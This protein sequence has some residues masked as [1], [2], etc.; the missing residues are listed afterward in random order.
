MRVYEF[1]AEGD[2]QTIRDLAE[3]LANTIRI[4]T[5]QVPLASLPAGLIV[6]RHLGLVTSPCLDGQVVHR[7]RLPACVLFETRATRTPGGDYVLMFPDG[8][9]YGGKNTKVNTMLAYRSSDQGRTWTGPTVAFDIDYNQHGFIPLIP[10]G[11]KRIYAFG[12]QPLW[13]KFDGHENAAIGYRFSDDDGRT[14]SPV[15]LT[16]PVNDPGY[17]GMSV[18][19]MCETDRGT[20]LLGTH[21]GDWTRKGKA[22]VV[23]RQYVLRSEDQGQTWTLLP[24]KRPGGWYV[25]EF[26]RMDELRPVG[27]GGGRVLALA[28]TCEGHLWELR[29]ED[30]GKIWTAPKPTPLVHPD[31]PPM[32]F[33]LADGK[34]LAA[35]HH[36]V[37]SG[38]H[39]NMRDRSQLWVSLSTDE[40]RTWSEPRFV[41]ANAL[42]RTLASDFQNDQCSYLDMFADGED[43]H[44]FLPHRWQRAL[45]LHLKSADLNRLPTTADLERAMPRPAPGD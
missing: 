43:L 35:F 14:W 13:N 33:P 24:G 15:Q 17:R 20:W 34:T 21:E 6:R 22:P 16:E 32:L 29:S 19:R 18:M 1:S 5:Q 25:P 37:H 39:F 7:A 3:R 2:L 12:T 42:D 45:H 27:L 31:A 38:G 23:T 10:R 28:R 44:L 4:G 40:G 11:S 9:H 8:G 41:L 26:E 30:D 36:N